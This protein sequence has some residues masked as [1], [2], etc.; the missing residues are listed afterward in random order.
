MYVMFPQL[1]S[2]ISMPKRTANAKFKIDRRA[3]GY[4]R[5]SNVRNRED[6]IS[7]ELQKEHIERC[8]RRD[9]YQIVKWVYDLGRTGGT[10]LR[11]QVIP[12]IDAIEKGG[13]PTI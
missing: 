4:I 9:G 12:L 11:R 6:M 3:V 5:V 2:T 8:A 13:P 1:R 10:F 7:P